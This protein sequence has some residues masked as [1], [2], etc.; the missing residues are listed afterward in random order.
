MANT[1]G[2]FERF[3]PLYGYYRKDRPA[4]VEVAD[5]ALAFTPV[6]T[7]D[8]VSEIVEEGRQDDPNYLQMGLMGLAEVLGYAP[9]VGPA[10]K[11]MARKTPD[12]VSE[13]L[14]KRKSEII[15]AEKIDN[16][17][18]SGKADNKSANE[19]N[20][21][22]LQTA[23]R[24]K[25]PH[26]KRAF[27][28]PKV[29]YVD[30]QTI[31]D[32]VAQFNF[33]R[34]DVGKFGGDLPS[35]NLSE[36]PFLQEKF[37]ASGQETL[38]ENI[39]NEGIKEP[40]EVE[41]V[42][43]DGGISISEGHHRLQAAIELGI[44]EVP[45]VVTTKAKPRAAGI[46]VMRPATLDT[47]GLQSGQTY[48]FSEL[49]LDQRLR[50]PKETPEEVRSRGGTVFSDF[51]T[52]EVSDRKF[53][54]YIT[55]MREGYYRKTE[56][57]AEGGEV[58][59]GIGSLNET[60]RG[61]TRGPRGI[62]SYVQYMANG[63]E[64]DKNFLRKLVK[65][66]VMAESSGDLRAENKRS[67]ALGLMQIRPSTARD[68]G[69]SVENVFTIAKKL[70]YETDGDESDGMVRQLLFIP[71]INVELG[72]QYLQAMLKK[73]PRTEDALR[74]YNAGPGKFAEFKASGKPISA[75]SDENRNYPLKV[76]AGIQ[77][78]NPNEPREMAAFN[79]SPET[80]SSIES[81]LSPP[82]SDLM[83]FEGP[84]SA[85]VNPIYDALGPRPVARPTPAGAAEVQIDQITGQPVV[86]PPSESLY[87]KYSPENMAQEAI[88]G[89]GGLSG[90]AR[91]MFR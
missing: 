59:S 3:H 64:I 63:G 49:G 24:E 11:T 67:G 4:S 1:E 78:I 56:G 91:D 23:E 14:N 54:Q 52:G 5:Q 34:Y 90:T 27:D 72:T 60:A 29:E 89:I 85:R 80:L 39:F 81:V 48:S 8:A 53:P 21:Q 16:I 6:G 32:N 88:S 43:S 62:G 12:F 46:E 69:Y 84:S 45:V 73:F 82:T 61:M 10:V 26:P 79:Q 87:E 7:A 33:P 70:G 35:G 75:L 15:P 19:I 28:N 13:F 68:P 83:M 31:A 9:A 36:N 77:G 47:G 66:V 18:L 65:G 51:A 74:A 57:F 55:P 17:I 20:K 22:V 50:R 2:F 40:I 86:V 58:M 42:L 30:T 71:E 44:P 25:I 37:D 41:V 38:K 76:V